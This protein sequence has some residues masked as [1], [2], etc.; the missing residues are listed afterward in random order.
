MLTSGSHEDHHLYLLTCKV[1]VQVQILTSFFDFSILSFMGP[2]YILIT[3]RLFQ[4]PLPMESG[5]TLAMS[6]LCFEKLTVCAFMDSV[7]LPAYS[8]RTC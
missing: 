6:L 1:D 5:P 7:W 8:G 3:A 2:D 4:N